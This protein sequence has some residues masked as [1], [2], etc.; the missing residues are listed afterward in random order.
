MC[1]KYLKQYVDSRRKKSIFEDLLKLKCTQI[2]S[3]KIGA[4]QFFY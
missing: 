3:I 1:I 2:S 4:P